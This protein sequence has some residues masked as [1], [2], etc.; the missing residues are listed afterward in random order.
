MKL[1]KPNPRHKRKAPWTEEQIIAERIHQIRM[2][3]DEKI[4]IIK[5]NIQTRG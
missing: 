2:E 3:L 5:K 4:K 1:P